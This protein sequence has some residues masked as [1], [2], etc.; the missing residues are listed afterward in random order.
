[1]IDKTIDLVIKSVGSGKFEILFT[2]AP[3]SL[4]SDQRKLFPEMYSLNKNIDASV[5]VILD[6]FEASLLKSLFTL[7]ILYKLNT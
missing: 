7:D 5:G 3:K 2:A 6:I 1:L 4:R